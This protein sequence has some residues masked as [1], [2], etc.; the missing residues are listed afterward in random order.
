[1]YRLRAIYHDGC[2]FA[3]LLEYVM[4]NVVKL[5]NNLLLKRPWTRPTDTL[6]PSR[7]RHLSLPNLFPSLR[8][9]HFAG[10]PTSVSV[11]NPS[12]QTSRLALLASQSAHT[13]VIPQ[14]FWGSEN[15]DLLPCILLL[16]NSILRYSLKDTVKDIII[17]FFSCCQILL[18]LVHHFQ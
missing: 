1:M 2:N 4:F 8:E 18:L 16:R 7:I 14:F 5:Y 15:Q 11:G 10:L 9:G 17:T 3:Y 6:D 13:F 12:R